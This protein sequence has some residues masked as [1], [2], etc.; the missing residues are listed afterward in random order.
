MYTTPQPVAGGYRFVDIAVGSAHTCAIDT[1]GKAWCWGNQANGRLGNGV[2]TTAAQPIPVEVNSDLAF[3][4]I[5][6]SV[7]H[8]CAI[9]TD[10]KAWCW[11]SSSN[12]KEARQQRHQRLVPRTG[13]GGGKPHVHFDL[14]LRSLSAV[15]TTAPPQ[16]TARTAAEATAARVSWA[17]GSPPTRI[18]GR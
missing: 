6:A 5:G 17:T 10:G 15:P 12:K 7:S 9:D 14:S 3:I 13:S 18:G 16:P 11:G 4:D 8:S 2:T 1:D